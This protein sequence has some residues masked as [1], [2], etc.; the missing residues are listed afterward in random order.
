MKSF[1]R[2]FILI[3]LYTLFSSH[4]FWL[5]PEKFIYK[6]GEMIN[7]R[8]LVGENF[9]GENWTGN[10]DRVKSLRFYFGNVSDKNLGDAISKEEGDSIQLAMADEGTAMIAF[11]SKNSFIEL[12][13][14][15][16]NDYLR[17]DGLTDALEYR[18]KHKDSSKAGKEFYQ[19]SVKTLIQV[20]DKTDHTYKQKTGL[21]IDIIPD[22]HPYSVAKDDDDFKVKFYFQGEPMKHTKVKVWHKVNNKIS[23]AE[24]TTDNDG[25]IKIF[26]TPTGQWMVSTVK[27]IHLENDPKAEWQSYWGTLTWGYE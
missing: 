19:R 10:I 3:L 20:G 21:P 18:M 9:N 24:Y 22:D 14:A 25:E 17:E 13:A 16:F 23:P 2:V 7:I 12:E 6:R 26:L 5:Q 27:M 4:E 15:K 11:E 1:L 8:F